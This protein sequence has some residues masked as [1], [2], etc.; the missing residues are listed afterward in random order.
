MFSITFPPHGHVGLI[1][2]KSESEVAQSFLTLCDPMDYSLPG[3][4]ICGIFQAR[5]LEWDAISFSRKSSQPRDW[6]QVSCIVG[7]CFA[8]WVFAKIQSSVFSTKTVYNIYGL[9][10]LHC[11]YGGFRLLLLFF[12]F[13]DLLF[14][15]CH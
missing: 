5:I 4:C 3:S 9:E 2:H 14:F 6:T 7:R 12:F 1:F 15:S 10:E 8:I 13:S 11:V